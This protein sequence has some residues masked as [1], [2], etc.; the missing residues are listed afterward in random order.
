MEKKTK[1]TLE[2]LY[3]EDK[4]TLQEI[5]DRFEVSRER[6]RCLMEKYEI[7]RGYNKSHKNYPQKYK[8][9]VDYFDDNRNKDTTY[10]RRLIINRE[11]TCNSC[12][13]NKHLHVHHLNYP[14]RALKDIV[15]LCASCHLALHRKGITYKKQQEICNKYISGKH[16]T[17]IS[18]EYNVHSSLIYYILRKHNIETRKTGNQNRLGVY[19]W[20]D[21]M[22]QIIE[23]KENGLSGYRIAKKLGIPEGTVYRYLKK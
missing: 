15:V 21:K 7:P 22:A 6:I 16:G 8:N 2:K 18:E 13:S 17:E 19:K 10:L 9:I 1:A 5:G 14:A 12:K 11:S 4:L 23:D 20:Q 3:N